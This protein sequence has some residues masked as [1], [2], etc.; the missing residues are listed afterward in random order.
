MD[1]FTAADI[2]RY[3]A[4]VA[5]PGALTAAINYYRAMFWGMLRQRPSRFPQLTM[6]V[7]VI[8]GEQDVA[9][10]KELA[11]PNRRIVPNVRV[12]RLPDA[13]HWVQNDA[14]DR[15]NALLL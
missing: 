7:L 14:P 5:Y 10:G 13:S 8:W 12:E 6:P 2:E 4:A 1:A 11:E 3:V 15:V 9:L